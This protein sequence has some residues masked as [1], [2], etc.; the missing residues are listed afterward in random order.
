MLAPPDLEF[1]AVESLSLELYLNS[2][3]EPH[4][5]GIIVQI[6]VLDVTGVHPENGQRE[7]VKL[8]IKLKPLNIYTTEERFMCDAVK[9]LK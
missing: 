9:R 2:Y 4:L 3:S 8:P 1:Q 7:T 5:F 6:T